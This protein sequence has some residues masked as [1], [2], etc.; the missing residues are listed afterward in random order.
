MAVGKRVGMKIALGVVFGLLAV[1][2][3]AFPGI[4]SFAIIGCLPAGSTGLTAYMIA[5]PGQTISGQTIDATGCD[6]GIYVPST[7]TGVTITGSTITGAND[8]GIFVQD[9]S[10]GVTI[11]DNMVTG[12]GGPGTHACSAISP[13]CINEDKGIELVGTSNS[14]ISGNTVQYNMADGGIGVADD[15]A[16]DPGAPN[17][18][19]PNAGNNNVIEN[20][21]VTDNAFGCGI[22]VA[23]YNAGEGVSGNIV[24]DNTV[25][26]TSPPPPPYVGGV[27]LADDTPGTSTTP[28][29]SMNNQIIDN[30]ITGGLIPGIIVHANAQYD[31]VINTL[32]QGNILSNNGFE[33]GQDA[34]SPVGINIVAEVPGLATITGTNVLNNNVTNDYY[35]VWYCNTSPSI[36]GTTGNPTIYVASCAQPAGVPEFP[37][38]TLGLS[39][40]L[41]LGFVFIALMRRMSLPLR[42]GMP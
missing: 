37:F 1:S 22:V 30:T 31:Q 39:L 17:P 38:A 8:H 27:V 11:T 12:N 40:V 18:G 19:V 21:I 24:Q 42:R 4:K 15:G 3:I 26:V 23:S 28:E 20:N 35:G 10:T 32:V 29:V 6:I 2:I 13:P 14:L 36:S 5:T 34:A 33:G 7:A 9:V 25:T 16:I 41:A